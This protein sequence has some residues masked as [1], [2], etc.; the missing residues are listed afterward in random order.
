MTALKLTQI[1]KLGPREAVSAAGAG[2]T[3]APDN[4]TR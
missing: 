3:L 1:G 4:P 2:G